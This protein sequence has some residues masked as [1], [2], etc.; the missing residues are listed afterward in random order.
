MHAVRVCKNAVA[1]TRACRHFPAAIGHSG[2]SGYRLAGPPDILTAP[3]RRRHP[4]DFD[5]AQPAL[6]A[7]AVFRINKPLRVLA[8]AGVAVSRLDQKRDRLDLGPEL[9]PRTQLQALHRAVRHPG[10]QPLAARVEL[11]LHL[12][13]RLH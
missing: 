3:S 11:D 13:T 4:D 2:M 7:P 12:P 8:G 10:Q 6:V 1:R 5:P 9:Q